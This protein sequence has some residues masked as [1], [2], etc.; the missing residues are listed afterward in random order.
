MQFAPSIA[1][2]LQASRSACFS[3]AGC[4]GKLGGTSGTFTSPN[5]PKNYP[6]DA[7]CTWVIQGPAHA[8]MI[9]ITFLKLDIEWGRKCE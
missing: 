1:I 5:F 6:D 2:N 9:D 3:D 7:D 8:T 4:G